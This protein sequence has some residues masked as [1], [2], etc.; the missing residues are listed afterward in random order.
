MLGGSSTGCTDGLV[1]ATVSSRDARADQFA[2]SVAVGFEGAAFAGA[3]SFT[4]RF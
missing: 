2:A 1:G 4:L 3:G